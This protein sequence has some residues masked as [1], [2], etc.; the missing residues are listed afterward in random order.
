[1]LSAFPINYQ[2]HIFFYCFRYVLLDILIVLAGFIGKLSIKTEVMVGR[3]GLIIFTFN[4]NS[5]EIY[6]KHLC[7][8]QF[9][10]EVII[11]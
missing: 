2:C 11:R 6:E 8:C 5:K 10:F 1:M 4:W 9:C 3:T 7:G